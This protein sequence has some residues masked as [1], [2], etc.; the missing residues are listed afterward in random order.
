MQPTIYSLASILGLVT[1]FRRRE[2]HQW[3][4]LYKSPV[5]F[6]SQA[7]IVCISTA[8]TIDVGLVSTVVVDLASTVVAES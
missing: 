2:Q 7:S 8:T 5:R 4:A 3:F 1:S 6:D